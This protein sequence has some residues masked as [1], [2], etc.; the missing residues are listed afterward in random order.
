MDI[1]VDESKNFVLPG[2]TRHYTKDIDIIINNLKI[3]GKIDFDKKVFYGTTIILFKPYRNNLDHIV[4]DAVELQIDNIFIN[5]KPVEFIKYTDSIDI[6]LTDKLDS[7][8]EYKLTVSYNTVPRKGL[9]FITPDKDHPD[10]KYQV[11]SQGEDEDSRYW[12]PCIDY[13]GIKFTTE[14]V[15]GVKK[16]Y[17]VISNGV[18][19]EKYESPDGLTWFDWVEDTKHSAYLTSIAVGDFVEIKDKW[20]DVDLYYYVPAERVNDADRTFKN[21]KDM[22]TFFSNFTGIRYPYKKY[23]Q[24]TVSDFIFGG[25]ENISST[26]LTDV[27]LHDE[28]AELNYK[29]EPLIAHELA[30]QWAGDLVTCKNWYHAWLN[31]GFATYFELLYEEHLL[32][33]DEFTMYLLNNIAAYMEESSTYMRPIVQRVYSEP[34]ELFDRHTYQKGSLVL[35][36]LRGFLGHDTFREGIK[37]YLKRYSESYAETDDFRKIMEE[38]SGKGL[39]QFFEQWIYR[40]GHPVL[41]ISWKYD[42]NLKNAIIDVKQ[43]NAFS[44][45]PLFKF[46]AT[47]RI[48]TKEGYVDR[49]FTISKESELFY[50]PLD[51]PPV[52][53]TFDPDGWVL[54]KTSFKKSVDELSYILN[55]S[56]STYEKIMAM[57]EMK[58]SYDIKAVDILA[59]QLKKDQF[60]GIQA[61]AASVLGEIHTDHALDGLLDNMN[62]K[63][64]MARTAVVKALSKYRDK[65][66]WNAIKEILSRGDQSYFVEAY[67]YTAIGKTKFIDGFDLLVDGLSKESF[68]DI[69][70]SSALKAMGDLGIEKNINYAMEYSSTDKPLYTRI[71]AIYALGKLGKN[72]DDIKDLLI[73]LLEDPYLQVS[74][75]AVA[76]LKEVADKTVIP[77]IDR[78]VEKDI[79]ARLKRSLKGLRRYLVETGKN[80]I[81]QLQEEIENLKER[82]RELLTRIEKLEKIYIKKKIDK[83]YNRHP[84]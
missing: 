56:N 55:N 14:V 34:I 19:K 43:K 9:Y 36:M 83:N 32:G 23:S 47:F 57:R 39:E 20:E 66:V 2:A 29:S 25:M 46:E 38:V 76:S 30:H 33:K 60:W 53:I 13:P 35:H 78:L 75:A 48:Y 45:N 74:M 44:K 65:K 37:E 71:G 51:K 16:P 61:E 59:G 81:E 3:Q 64:A 15:I 50:I 41:D 40:A 70:R 18:L 80:N 77:V 84:K 54:C 21:T 22:L 7:G 49:N 52:T 82:N 1:T 67:A 24:V 27:T 79:Q 28:K 10:K 58:S 11:W 26:T 73:K 8:E 72:R 42:I 6:K 62:L 17:I 5:D 12:F 63:N 68:M 31:E 69:I 4:L